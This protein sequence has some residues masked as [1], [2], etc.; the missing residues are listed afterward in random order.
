MLALAVVCLT[1]MGVI[2]AIAVL[3]RPSVEEH[4]Q[5]AVTSQDENDVPDQE[6]RLVRENSSSSLCYILIVSPPGTALE[7][8]LT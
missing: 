6:S 5:P 3:E 1:V 7:K 4:V 8:M 2:L